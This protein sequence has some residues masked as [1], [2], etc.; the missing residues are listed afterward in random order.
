MKCRALWLAVILVVL[1]LMPA[2]SAC[3]RQPD[4]PL[5]FTPVTPAYTSTPTEPPV[6]KIYLP[7]VFKN[8]RLRRK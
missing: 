6:R 1:A 5:A 2:F 4:G 8:Y 3:S 7:A